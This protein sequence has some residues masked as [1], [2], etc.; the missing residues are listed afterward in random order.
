MFNRIIQDSEGYLG[1][2]MGISNPLDVGENAK[3]DEDFFNTVITKSD[4]KEDNQ[5]IIF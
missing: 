5:C 4:A 1:K 2:K 3:D